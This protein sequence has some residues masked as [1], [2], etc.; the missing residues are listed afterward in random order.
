MNSTSIIY[1][2]CLICLLFFDTTTALASPASRKVSIVTGANGY[3]GREIVHNLLGYRIPIDNGD[4]KIICLVRQ[5]RVE[6]E[7]RYWNSIA[8]KNPLPRGC[9]VK[10]MAYDMLDGG[11]TLLDALDHAF[12]DCSS[13]ADI[14][15]DAE[16]DTDV[17][18][19]CC[20]YHLASVF[21]PVDDHR[22]MAL[23]NVKGAEDV[24]KAVAKLPS[25]KTKVVFTS[26]MAAVRGSGQ[27][28]RNGKWY[29]HEDWNTVSELGANWGA[30]YQWSKAE[31][32]K[33]SWE[34]ANKH[35]IPFVALC[36]AFIFG[37]PADGTQSN[38]YSLTI[39]RSWIQG[40]SSVQSRLCVDVRDVARAHV[41]AGNNAPPSILGQRIIL[42]REARIPSQDLAEELKRIAKE[43]GVGDPY[44]ISYDADFDGGAIKIGEREV[45]CVERANELLGGLEFRSPKETLADMAIALLEMEK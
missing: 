24:I 33:R 41:L 40:D 30:S 44:G 21:S 8:Q 25:R 10:V 29:T 4:D 39:V 16:T 2:T 43:T 11:E 7:K 6:E 19:E 23:D 3:L 17:D 35:S 26:S 32:E 5:R 34:L 27:T 12:K 1:F 15:N 45:E 42:S 9:E 18:T 37:P 38:S 13:S 20:V 36:P 31:S 22:Q 14:G 28:P